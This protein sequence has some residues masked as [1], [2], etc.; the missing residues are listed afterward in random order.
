[1]ATNEQIDAWT[2]GKKRNAEAENLKQH[3]KRS[4]ACMQLALA[5]PDQT[6]PQVPAAFRA[7]PNS[8]A[9]TA[10]FSCLRK[11]AER[12]DY[13]EHFVASL[14]NIRLSYTGQEL[15]QNDASVFMSILHCAAGNFDGGE[16]FIA[17]F[18]VHA[19]LKEIGWTTNSSG[20]ARVD[21][22][23]TRLKANALRMTADEEKTGFVGSLLG[24]LTFEGTEKNR[25]YVIKIH[26]NIVG[27]FK[28][29]SYTRL[30]LRQR[31]QIRSP[32][33]KWL[34]SFW[35]GH[36]NPMPYTVALIA[37]LCG[38]KTK[39]VYHFRTM[40]RDA[41]EELVREGFLAEFYIDQNDLLHVKRKKILTQDSPREV[42]AMSRQ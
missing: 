19:F 42:Q 22:S 27:L 32:L 23:I 38:S 8:L 9:R 1:M 24:D 35:S 36:R 39:K 40:L 29:E 10:L 12:L 21:Q 30:L 33:G 16:Y 3:T 13:K 11:E 26:R 14:A 17:R 15:S 31:N 25:I 6:L 18:S 20:Y 28:R 5:L 4:L 37:T 2:E 7:F 41:C 34:H